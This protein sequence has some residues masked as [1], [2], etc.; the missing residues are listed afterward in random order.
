ML[1]Y[2]HVFRICLL[3][4][5]FVFCKNATDLAAQSSLVGKITDEDTG[6]EFIGANILITKRGIFIQGESTDIDGNF[7]IELASGTYDMEVSYTGY[8][9][10]KITDIEARDGEVVK[11]DVQMAVGNGVIEDF[12]IFSGGCCRSPLL[13]HD[14]TFTGRTYEQ[15]EI[16]KMPTRN[17]KSM[18]GMTGGISF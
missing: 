2:R 4:F 11:L 3:L 18:V 8:P 12:I 9:S 13:R 15:T 14:E 17:I 10:Q 16:Q 6:E 5:L 1:N 7:E